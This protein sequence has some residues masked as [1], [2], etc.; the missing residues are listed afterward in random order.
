MPENSPAQDSNLIVRTLLEN[1]TGSLTTLVVKYEAIAKDCERLEHHLSDISGKVSNIDE[2]KACV[3]RVKEQSDQNASQIQMVIDEIKASRIDVLQMVSAAS[4]SFASQEE[5]L[6]SIRNILNA[7]QKAVMLEFD[8]VL[9]GQGSLSKGQTNIRT[10]L[11]DGQ[12][13]IT[14]TIAPISKFSRMLSTPLGLAIFLILFLGAIWTVIELFNR[15][16]R[17]FT[18]KPPVAIVSAI[19]TNSADYYAGR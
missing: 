10:H 5:K 7:A 19:T 3:T 13:K 6:E 18:P 11:S 4:L 15:T 8:K 9:T 16:K 1:L 12:L 17:T 2:I 14:D